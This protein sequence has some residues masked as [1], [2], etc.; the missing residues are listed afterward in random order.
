MNENNTLK[1]SDSQNEQLEITNIEIVSINS[2][3]NYLTK[4]GTIVN[5]NLTSPMLL[6]AEESSNLSTKST[7]TSQIEIMNE[8]TNSSSISNNNLL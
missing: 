3:E 6:D 2:G 8:N 5:N 1:K 4:N 7:N